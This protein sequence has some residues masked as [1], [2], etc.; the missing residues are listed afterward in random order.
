MSTADPTGQYRQTPISTPSHKLNAWERGGKPTGGTPRFVSGG[1]GGGKA[2]GDDGLPLDGSGGGGGAGAGG[3]SQRPEDA[4]ARAEWD[5]EQK[6]LDRSWYD[7]DGARDSEYDPFQDQLE[8][9]KRKEEKMKKQ[10][11]KRI[12]EQR[13]RLNEDQ[14]RWETNRMLQSG[15]VHR[16]AEDE[17]LMEEDESRTHLLV[18]HVVPPFLDGRTF[19][20]HPKLRYCCFSSEIRALWMCRAP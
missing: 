16:I 15:A 19:V 20:P 2:V 1:G 18:H 7:N 13:R 6:R 14:E 10:Q 4:V 9:V 12:S 5:E 11:G 3:S 17:E 8:Y